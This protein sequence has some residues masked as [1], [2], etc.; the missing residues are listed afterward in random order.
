MTAA[1]VEHE[2]QTG[3]GFCRVQIAGPTT[4]V[5]VAVPTAVPLAALLPSIVTFAEQDWA[6][7]QD[8]AAPHGWALSRLDGTRLDPAA[9]LAV[10]G[11]REGEL[12]LLHSARDRVGEPLYDDVVELL[13]QGADE[14]GWSPRD[15]RAAA[16]VLGG[17][18]VLGAVWISVTVG[19]PLAGVALGMLTLLLLGGGAA[20]S[21]AA[22]DVP[23]G[24]VV[25]A[26]AAISGAAFGVVLLG[27]PFG[28]AHVVV[29]AAVA[30][31]VAAT[32]P[33]LINGGDAVFV[34]IGLTALLARSGERSCCSPGPLPP[35]PRRWSRPSRSP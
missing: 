18:A 8:G 28:A 20:L 34:G 11:V 14:S 33:A 22:A 26:L 16:A 31:L 29:A 25:G 12:L 7:Q 15:T 32:G 9:A 5:D 21:H 24:T 30:V 27:P 3:G 2:S 17:L 10:T 4:R 6:A 23:A 35:P 1:V 13:G 19:T